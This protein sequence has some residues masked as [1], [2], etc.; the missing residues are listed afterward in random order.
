MR[1]EDGIWDGGRGKRMLVMRQESAATAPARSLV[2]GCGSA[3]AL[4]EGV[5]ARRPKGEAKVEV[6]KGC[7]ETMSLAR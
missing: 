1:I 7:F 2:G 6:E 4:G 5:D 3:L